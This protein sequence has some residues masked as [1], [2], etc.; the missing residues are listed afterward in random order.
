MDVRILTFQREFLTIGFTKMKSLI[1]HFVAKFCPF[2]QTLKDI[3]DDFA[4][5][6]TAASDDGVMSGMHVIGT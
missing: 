3:F 1:H 6:T 4:C 5:A 2:P